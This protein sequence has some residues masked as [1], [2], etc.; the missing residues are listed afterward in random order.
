VRAWAHFTFRDII[1]IA[2]MTAPT[3][4]ERLEQAATLF[5]DAEPALTEAGKPKQYKIT[6][7][8]GNHHEA[9]FQF[10]YEFRNCFQ[11]RPKTDAQLLEQSLR[12]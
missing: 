9:R 7:V 10:E 1:P 6:P 8:G 11:S 5:Q 12:P 2:G 4:E 3:A